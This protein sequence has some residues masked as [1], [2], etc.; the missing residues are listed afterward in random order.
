VKTA[1]DFTG[2]EIIVKALPSSETLYSCLPSHV[3]FVTSCIVSRWAFTLFADVPSPFLAV[4]PVSKYG[5]MIV[6]AEWIAGG[7]NAGACKQT[8]KNQ[9]A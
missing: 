9:K 7:I 1:D 8:G 5:V 4:A 6:S 2:F 3:P